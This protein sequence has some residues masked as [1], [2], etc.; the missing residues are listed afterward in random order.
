MPRKIC[1][2]PEKSDCFRIFFAG[3]QVEMATMPSIAPEF[4]R[5]CLELNDIN[6][7][8]L[9]CLLEDHSKYCKVALQT[10]LKWK[11]F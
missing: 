10:F 2:V 7:R 3:E 6:G 9:A 8:Q 4:V 5:L 1:S 11:Y